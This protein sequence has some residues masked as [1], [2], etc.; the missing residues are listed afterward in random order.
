M[1]V[2]SRASFEDKEELPRAQQIFSTLTCLQ[3][4]TWLLNPWQYLHLYL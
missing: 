3:K 1:V 2:G 4:F